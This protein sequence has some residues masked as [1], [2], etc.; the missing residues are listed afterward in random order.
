MKGKLL[1]KGEPELILDKNRLL[2]IGVGKHKPEEG[3]SHEMR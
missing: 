3:Q 1:L 2:T